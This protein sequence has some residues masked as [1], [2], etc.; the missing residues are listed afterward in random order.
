MTLTLP[1][2]HSLMNVV[3]KQGTSELL[4]EVKAHINEIP[5]IC[6]EGTFQKYRFG[7][8]MISLEDN[9]YLYGGYYYDL[10]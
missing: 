5:N 9:I 7:S 3:K 6:H 2:L 4:S 8:S 10:Q 1:T